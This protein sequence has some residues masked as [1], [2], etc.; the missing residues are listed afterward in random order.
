MQ[1]RLEQAEGSAAELQAQ[2]AFLQSKLETSQ[3]A[4]ASLHARLQESAQAASD[5]QVKVDT[6]HEVS[7]CSLPLHYC[8]GYVTHLGCSF[9]QCDRIG[10]CLDRL[11]QC[12]NVTYT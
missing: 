6:L 12:C 2:V 10:L 4:E 11:G 8:S 9:G 3:G 7:Y 1:Q 5:L